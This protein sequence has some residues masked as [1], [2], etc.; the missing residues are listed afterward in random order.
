MEGFGLRSVLVWNNNN[1]MVRKAIRR[2]HCRY[3]EQLEVRPLAYLASQ[4]SGLV[5]A[6][7]QFWSGDASETTRAVVD[8]SVFVMGCQNFLSTYI[9]VISRRTRSD[10]HRL[11]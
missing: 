1:I 8:F 3:P 9:V 7:T 11:P 2:P 4:A 10:N 5:N 6:D